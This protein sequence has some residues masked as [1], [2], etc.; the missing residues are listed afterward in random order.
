V[1]TRVGVRAVV[2]IEA[3]A[4]QPVVKLQAA[5]WSNDP[6]SK[7]RSQDYAGYN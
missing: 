3:I 5:L 1:R 7:S 6:N 2:S 4:V